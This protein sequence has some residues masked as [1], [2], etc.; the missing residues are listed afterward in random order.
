[1]AGELQPVADLL[2]RCLLEGRV[3]GDA[4]L[5]DAFLGAEGVRCAK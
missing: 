1:M 4:G 2:V 5:R 3:P